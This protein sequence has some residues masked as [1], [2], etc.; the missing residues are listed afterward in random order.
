[1]PNLVP[2]NFSP[3][4]QSSPPCCSFVCRLAHHFSNCFSLLICP[5]FFLGVLQGSLLRPPPSPPGTYTSLGN[6]CFPP[7]NREARI[8]LRAFC[9]FG[10]TAF[11]WIDRIL[12]WSRGRMRHFSQPSLRHSPFPSEQLLCPTEADPSAFLPP[13]SSGPPPPFFCEFERVVLPLSKKKW[14][15]SGLTIRLARS[16]RAACKL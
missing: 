6:F 11:L 15:A 8:V 4:P 12:S 9:S 1:L 16:R 3:L 2:K 5:L 14:S 7:W 13:L 10:A